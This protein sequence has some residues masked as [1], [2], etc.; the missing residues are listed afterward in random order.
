[1]TPR[2]IRLA[3]T[4]LIAV[5]MGY[6]VRGQSADP[7]AAL[8]AMA[9]RYVLDYEQRFTGIV[10]E[11]HETQR[12]VKANGAT[13]KQRMLTADIV[14]VK[15]G[16][17]TLTF[18]DVMAVDGKAVGNREARLQKLFLG[19]SR[20]PLS[21]ARAIVEESR[22]YDL[23]FPRLSSP[24]LVPLAIVKPAARERFRFA[25]A[26]AGVTVEEVGSPT[27]YRYR[28][29]GMRTMLD[30]PLRGRLTIDAASGAI[31]SATLTE[32]SALFVGS[33]EV[34]YT[35]DPVLGLLVPVQ[36]IE[37]YRRP[38]KP[39]DEHLEVSSEYSNFRRFEVKV[40]EQIALPLNPAP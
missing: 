17:R 34:R 39:K 22:R 24:L 1:M 30:M 9:G 16:D 37:T 33:V 36:L 32:S 6:G 29:K 18:R 5:L 40:E 27:L 10:G 38:A 31:R 4:L 28:E 8:V 3:L 35:S 19:S 14:V 15:V 25:S 11:V 12:L 26:D 21:Q 13:S 2:Y 23:T 7:A 20:D